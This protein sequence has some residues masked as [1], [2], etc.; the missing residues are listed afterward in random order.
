MPFIKSPRRLALSLL[1]LRVG[2]AAMMAPWALD[3][4][5]RPDHA[6]SVISRFY[7][8]GEVMPQFVLAAGVAQIAVVAAFAAGFARM[9][10]YGAVLAMHA[11]STFSTWREYLAPYE[12]SNLL[13]FA[14]WPALGACLALFLLR[15]HDRLLS[16]AAIGGTRGEH[17]AAQG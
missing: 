15:D 3:K 2:I 17:P 1:G 13:L 6:I 4:L 7:V 5:I 8:P 12:A 9:W 10:T 11:V 16:V 14:S